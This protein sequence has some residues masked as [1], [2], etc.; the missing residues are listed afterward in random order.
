MDQPRVAIV[1]GSKSDADVMVECSAV[2][3]ELGVSC[4]TRVLS[5]HRSPDRLREF[6]L[7]APSR[8]V[9]VFVAAAGMA[10]ALPGVIAAHTTLPVIG[11]P[12]AKAG[13]SG[14]DALLSI[15]QMPPGVPVACMALNGA[16][17][18]GLFAAAIL[19]LQDKAVASAL[20]RYRHEQASA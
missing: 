15:S 16:R 8:G 12:I 2:L 5:A 17:N 1:I 14:L 13:M 7:E 10:A 3:K 18:A 4:E 9:E 6:V 11:V 19:A 20:D